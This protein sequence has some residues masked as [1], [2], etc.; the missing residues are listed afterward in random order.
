MAD[1]CIIECPALLDLINRIEVLRNQLPAVLTSANA[2]ILE[3]VKAGL[4]TLYGPHLAKYWEMSS[5]T[6][7]GGVL[8][9]VRVGSTDKRVHGFEFGTKPHMIFPKRAGGV[10][11]FTPHGATSPVFA[12][13]VAHPGTP[14]HN[15]RDALKLRLSITARAEW[16]QVLEAL[17]H[18]LQS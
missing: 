7:G 3:Q 8:A 1:T 4:V 10:L 5:S 2:R 9:Q 15:K 14:A 18:T 17:L 11:R 13:R 16:E 12:R 6:P